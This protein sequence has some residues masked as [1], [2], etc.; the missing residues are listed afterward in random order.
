MPSFLIRGLA[1]YFAASKMASSSSSSTTPDID[2]VAEGVVA[3]NNNM[4]WLIPFVQASGY[5]IEIENP[6]SH[7]KIIIDTDTKDFPFLTSSWMRKYDKNDLDKWLTREKEKEN[8][9]L[10]AE[11]RGRAKFGESFT[12]TEKDIQD[13]INSR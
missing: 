10:V 1:K 4:R 6:K 3:W 5:R 13:A 2:E 9:R 11:A 7:E 12:P 8:V